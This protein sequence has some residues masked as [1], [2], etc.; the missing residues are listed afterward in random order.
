MKAVPRSHAHDCGRRVSPSP[1]T[2]TIRHFAPARPEPSDKSGKPLTATPSTALR[3]EISV[4]LTRNFRLCGKKFAPLRQKTHALPHGFSHFGGRNA[5]IWQKT[6][7]G[8]NISVPFR[9]FQTDAG[10]RK[11]R[12]P[13]TLCFISAKKHINLSNRP[14][15]LP[16]A[17][18]V[19]PSP[20]FC[21]KRAARHVFS[22]IPF[23]LPMFLFNFAQPNHL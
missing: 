9:P 18:S 13:A 11:N 12:L 1:G 22:S 3:Q 20:H 17:L 15:A 21:H 19:T 23:A 2:A 7:C 6:P 16:P 10:Q 5:P 4:F 8:F 14:T